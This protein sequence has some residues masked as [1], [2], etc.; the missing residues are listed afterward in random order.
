MDLKILIADDN[1]GF[2]EKLKQFLSGRFA[3]K[4]IKIVFDGY[5]AVDE[6]IKN[7]FDVVILDLIMP[8][9]DGLGVLRKAEALNLSH[10]PVFI[11]LS[12]SGLRK[13]IQAAF[14]LGAEYFMVRPVDF[15]ELAFRIEQFVPKK[16]KEN[17]LISLHNDL[18][19]E[20]PIENKI[21]SILDEL[22]FQSNLLGYKYLLT[23]LKMLS[24]DLSRINSVTKSLYAY[25]ADEWGSTPQRVERAIRNAI[26]LA[27]S[28]GNMEKILEIFPPDKYTQK[29]RPT[30]SE[31]MITIISECWNKNELTSKAR[32]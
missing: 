5:Q 18:Q 22:G 21:K 1:A 6:L 9:L 10:K 29:I 3:T 15:D 25:L 14:E 24:Q 19:S 16:E 13:I 26:E 12:A 2:A 17:K 32:F 20:E 27:W 11:M 28:R 31:F 7:D 23:A 30:N 4:S 8:G